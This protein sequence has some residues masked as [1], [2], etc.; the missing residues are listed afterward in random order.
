MG[1]KMDSGL[2]TVPVYARVAIIINVTKPLENVLRVLLENSRM[3]APVHA[4]TARLIYVINQVENVM[5][6]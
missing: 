6:R 5:V 2:L 1:A 3:T 4:Q